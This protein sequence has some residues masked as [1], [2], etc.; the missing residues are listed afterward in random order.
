MP[1][2]IAGRHTSARSQAITEEE[3]SVKA[4]KQFLEESETFRTLTLQTKQSQSQEKR[5]KEVPPPG[6]PGR[7]R[8]R[9]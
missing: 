9:L 3:Q 5:M 1:S 2:P 6:D 7:R 4:H 8:H